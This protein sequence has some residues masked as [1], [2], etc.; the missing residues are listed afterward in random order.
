MSEITANQIKAWLRSLP[1]AMS[2]WSKRDEAMSDAVR[3]ALVK[4]EKLE[5]AIPREFVEKWASNFE[6]EVIFQINASLD[7]I[8]P[9]VNIQSFV[10]A[11]LRE[12]GHEV[13]GENERT[14]SIY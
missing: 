1:G 7:E 10:I 5:K 6:H 11:M 14:T 8:H 12:L 9:G 2:A 3:A 13:E 4:P